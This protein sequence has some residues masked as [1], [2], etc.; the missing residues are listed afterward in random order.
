VRLSGKFEP[1]VGALVYGHLIPG[2]DINQ[3]M[4]DM[5]KLRKLQ[6]KDLRRAE[7]I[8]AKEHERVRAAARGRRTYCTGARYFSPNYTDLRP[9][10]RTP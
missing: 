9:P 5:A 1:G 10:N 2:H 8:A 4:E 3:L 7:L 6:L